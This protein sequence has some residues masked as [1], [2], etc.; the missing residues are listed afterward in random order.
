[1]SRSLFDD[2]RTLLN[3]RLLDMKSSTFVFGMNVTKHD[4]KIVSLFK[5]VLWRLRN[6]CR[7]AQNVNKKVLFDSLIVFFRRGLN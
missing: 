6:K 1:V 4:S 5:F 7:T 3:D 2:V